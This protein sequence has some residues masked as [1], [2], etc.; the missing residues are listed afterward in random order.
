MDVD[1]MDFSPINIKQM[2]SVLY[3]NHQQYSSLSK[4]V[5]E[6]LGVLNLWLLLSECQ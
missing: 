3:L 1:S 6:M 2:A 5:V 4:Q